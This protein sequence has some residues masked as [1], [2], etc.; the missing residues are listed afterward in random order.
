[1]RIEKIIVP[2]DFSQDAQVAFETAYDLARQLGAKLYLLHVQEESMLRTAVKEGLLQ[3]D[4][5]DEQL[6]TEVERLIQ[7]RFSEMLAGLGWS[8]VEIERLTR[9]GNPKTVIIEYANEINADIVV[10]GMRG[11][12]AMSTIVSAV[13]GSV[14]ESVIRK[15]PCSVLIVRP[16]HSRS[17]VRRAGMP[18]Q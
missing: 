16:E 13:I 17:Q 11:M 14:T 3:A 8:E 15:S 5:T 9:R 1:M 6:Q 12:T 2:T 10:I 7:A 4:S 18:R